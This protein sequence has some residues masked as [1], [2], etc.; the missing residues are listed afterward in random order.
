METSTDTEYVDTQDTATT[1]TVET[2]DT[3]D[4]D[5][6]SDEEFANH[7]DGSSDVADEDSIEAPQE[8]ITDDLDTLYSSQMEDPDALLDKPVYLKFEGK[9][10]KVTSVKEL[11][12]LSEQ[13]ISFSKKNQ[14]M[15]EKQQLLDKLEAN[16]YSQEDLLALATRDNGEQLQEVDTN[17]K[18]I[19]TVAQRILDS[20]YADSFKEVVAQLPQAVVDEF[21]ST[22][23]ALKALAEDVE[24][25]FLPSIMPQITRAMTIEGKDFKSAYME[26]A[27][28]VYDKQ[29]TSNSKRDTLVSQPTSNT[30]KVQ[31]QPSAWQM[32]DDDFDKYFDAM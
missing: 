1:E 30:S 12:N 4:V 17:A 10:H 15:R 29:A 28:G 14:A 5:T 13:G 2:V 22:P 25:G 6:M 8:P 21:V 11:K 24:S 7:M 20:T 31:T 27:K 18:D 32:S 19:D 9:V 23:S 3:V 26:V 16:G